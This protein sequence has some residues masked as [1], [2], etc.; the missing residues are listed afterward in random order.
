MSLVSKE[1]CDK[2]TMLRIDEI[3]DG[4]LVRKAYKPL[5]EIGGAL[6]YAATQTKRCEDISHGVMSFG[7]TDVIR[8]RQLLQTENGATFWSDRHR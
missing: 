2:E 5:P 6:M 3:S 7:V 8:R 4:C 1:L